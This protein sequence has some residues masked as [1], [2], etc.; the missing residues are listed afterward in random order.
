M[1]KMYPSDDS[2]EYLIKTMVMSSIHPTKRNLRGGG[3]SS[4]VENIKI[5][6]KNII[7]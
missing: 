2:S 7:K 3:P 6:Y 1:A 4:H 5:S